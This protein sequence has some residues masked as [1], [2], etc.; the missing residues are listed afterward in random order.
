MVGV[1]FGRVREAEVNPQ[2]D[3]TLPQELDGQEELTV[4]KRIN[5]KLISSFA[6]CIGKGK[7]VRDKSLSR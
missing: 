4:T 6:L 3:H 7:I 1:N 5:H 2:G